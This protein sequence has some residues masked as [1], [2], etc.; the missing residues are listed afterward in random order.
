MGILFFSKDLRDLV[1][2]AIRKR[3]ADFQ[4]EDLRP[5]IEGS[6]SFRKILLVFSFPPK[7]A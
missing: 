4:R 7:L 3:Y 5:V 1:S 6:T 2:F